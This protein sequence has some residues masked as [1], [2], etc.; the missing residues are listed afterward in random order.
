[1][2]RILLFLLVILGSMPV[3]AQTVVTVGGYHGFCDKSQATVLLTL[4]E[5]DKAQ[6]QLPATVTVDDLTCDVH[7]T[8]L[9][10]VALE[11]DAAGY[12]DFSPTRITLLT[13]SG[14]LA[15][16]DAEVRHRGATSLGYDKKNYAVKL[17]DA[18]GQSL[19]ESLLGMRSDNSWILDA[20]ASDVA[21]M[22][23]RVS[24]DMW[25]DFSTPPYYADLEPS[26]SN[27]THGQFVEAFIADRYWGLYCLTEK[28]DRKQLKL[29]K[30]KDD[31]VRGI[32][33]KSVGYDNLHLITD[34]DPDATSFTWQGWE[35]AYPDVRKDEPFDWMPL[36][37][38]VQFLCQEAPSFDIKY[39][40]PERADLPVWMDYNLF[41]DLLHADDNACKNQ[42]VYCR[43]ITALPAEPLSICP[44]DLDATWGRDW[45]RV[46]LAPESNCNVA[47]A[48]NYHLYMSQGDNGASID[49][50]WAQ[51]RE[52]PFTADAIWPYF[53]RYFDLFTTSG[54]G[55]R[56]EQRWNGINGVELDFEAEREYIH[57]WIPRRIS[58]L[59]GDYHYKPTEGIGSVTLP[60]S[61]QQS[62][63]HLLP[64][65]TPSGQT[66]ARCTRPSEVHT[67]SL[68][69]GIYIVAGM[70]III[71]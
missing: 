59:D 19:D 47:N 6:A 60:P 16:Y 8:T 2:I 33:Y 30:Y 45:K 28:I 36:F 17:L 48:V 51:L 23:N 42:Y 13:P 64:V 52:G 5:E 18:D 37:D 31:T 44:W 50:R 55:A 69:P 66:V 35:S 24:T 4:C 26:M 67:L 49:A 14:D 34:P 63:S 20:M 1:M 32:L 70:K 40:L 39:H 9:P 53:E 10:L 29:K 11:C 46:M 43:D 27:G 7:T 12:I 62:I 54:A 57:S 3:A 65:V 21:R 61:H 56:E 22:R 41:C 15:V 25:L 38:F 71:K 68:P 58:Y